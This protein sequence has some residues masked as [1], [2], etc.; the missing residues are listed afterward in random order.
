MKVGG[1][2]SAKL[3]TASSVHFTVGCPRGQFFAGRN[4]ATTAHEESVVQRKGGLPLLNGDLVERCVLYSGAAHQNPSSSVL[5]GDGERPI[6]ANVKSQLHLLP[7]Q[8][9]VSSV[10]CFACTAATT[11]IP[12]SPLVIYIQH[13]VWVSLQQIASTTDV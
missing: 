8:E 9:P 12:K 5:Y 1:V 4:V 7:R 2:E 10:D 6:T 13:A 11:T 3:K